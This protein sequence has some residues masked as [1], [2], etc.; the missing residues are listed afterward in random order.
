MRSKE[1]FEKICEF[2]KYHKG[3]V[4]G[5]AIGLLT[6]I[7][8]LTIGFF[9]TLLIVLCVGLGIFLGMNPSVREKIKTVFI[10]LFERIADRFR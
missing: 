2:Y 7:F 3:A 4:N 9:R 8:L 6:A 10:A 5:C 1:M